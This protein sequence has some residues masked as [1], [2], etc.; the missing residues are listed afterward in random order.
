VLDWFWAM[1]GE[2]RWRERNYDSFDRVFV[3][4]SLVKRW[5]KAGF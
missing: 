3:M 2:R 4:K 5:A 1:E